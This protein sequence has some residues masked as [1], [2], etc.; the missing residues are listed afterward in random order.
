MAPDFRLE[1]G[2]VDKTGVFRD[3]LLSL[4]FVD[5]DGGQADTLSIKLD[6]RDLRCPIPA[7]DEKIKLWL[8]YKDVG[9][10]YAGFFAV[11]DSESTFGT[12]TLSVNA[13]SA[14]MTDELKSPKT[15]PWHS[16]TFGALANT[17]AGEHGLTLAMH[18]MLT[19]I[20]LGH[21]DQSEESDLHLLMR[22]S[23]SYDAVLKIADNNIVI[24]P[25]GVGESVSGTALEPA[26]ISPGELVGHTPGSVRA[27]GRSKYN[28]VRCKWRDVATAATGQAEA[29]SGGPWYQM[30]DTVATEPAAKLKAEAK[31]KQLKRGALTMNVNLIG[32]LKYQA[33]STCVLGDGF[34]SDYAGMQWL[35]SRAQHSLGNAGFKTSLQC[36]LVELS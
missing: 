6:D 14:D 23:Q 19:S 7:Y 31:L 16:L 18:Q 27:S 1:I 3:R 10:I 11:N 25:K 20:E 5:N 36:E 13:Q 4:D 29:G 21:I 30:R 15:R 2:G 17:V 8:G 9:L 35:I 12:K 24:T 34:K 33:G 28:G 22:L 26:V 32:S